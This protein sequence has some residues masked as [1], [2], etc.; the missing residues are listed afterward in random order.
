[1]KTKE[2]CIEINN[3][4]RKINNWR[5]KI[6]RGVYNYLKSNIG[7]ASANSESSKDLVGK[8]VEEEFSWYWDNTENL[9]TI[10]YCVF[11]NQ[12]GDFGDEKEINVD[13]S[14]IDKYL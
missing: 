6:N 11:R 2:I 4:E 3:L 9:I 10:T 7:I 8:V 1:M 5:T 14:V 12:W 13:P